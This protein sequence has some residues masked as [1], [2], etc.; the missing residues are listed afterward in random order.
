MANPCMLWAGLPSASP[1]AEAVMPGIRG[2][3]SDS[4]AL[5]NHGQEPRAAG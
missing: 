3:T 5:G 4:P 2:D 1:P